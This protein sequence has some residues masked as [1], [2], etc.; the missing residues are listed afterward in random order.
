MKICFLTSG[1]DPFDDRIFYHMA[2]SLAGHNHSVSIITSTAYKTDVTDGIKINCFYGINLS[3]REKVFEFINRLKEDN[4]E[5]IICSEPLPVYAAHKYR[6]IGQQRAK[7]IYDI[8]EWYPSKKNLRVYNQLIKWFHLIRLL[9]FNIWT[10]YLADGFIFGEWYKSRPYRFIFPGKPFIFTS[11]YPDLKY[12]KNSPPLL[13]ERILRLSYSGK[14]SIDKGFGYYIDV[15]NL[16]SER[17]PD[18]KIEVKII[19]WHD[20]NCEKYNTDLKLHKTKNISVNRYDRQSFADFI[21]LIKDTDIFIDLRVI[22]T[23]NNMCL[24]VKLFYYAALGR[25]VIFSNLKAIRKEIDINSFGYLVKP[26]KPEE[27]VAI[28]IE[29]LDN[30]E[31]YYSHCKSARQISEEQYNWK[32]I[33]EEFIK[34]ITCGQYNGSLNEFRMPKQIRH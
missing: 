15:I 24:P 31:K 3:K 18:L 32:F 21:D 19:G 5:I 20:N 28:L 14:I 29:Y 16:L 23:E 25:P 1:H 33:E 7:V 12:I 8:T 26:E 13:K 2:R 6:K 27:T 22:D 9:T 34:F 10:S 4:P 11:Y 30:P 17:L